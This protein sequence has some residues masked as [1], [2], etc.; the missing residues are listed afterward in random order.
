[1][2]ST[3]T[4]DSAA[5]AKTDRQIIQT[6]GAY[7]GVI[8]QAQLWDTK[9]GATMLG[10]NFMSEHG[11]EA[12]ISFCIVKSDGSESYGMGYLHSIMTCIGIKS[13]NPTKGRVR[14][15]DG[16]IADGIRLR[17]IE[18]PIGL[19]IQ[20]KEDEYDGKRYWR[21]ELRRVFDPMSRKTASEIVNNREPKIIDQLVKTIKDIPM[22][23][24]TYPA[25]RTTAEPAPSEPYP[26]DDLVF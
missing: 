3:I 16:S 12:D 19:V 11:E 25:T 4:C 2:I 14:Q 23:E 17:E 7:A 5:A 9:N 10:L 1:M 24:Q 18:K 21:K 15:R 13:A 20:L 26:D 22:Q 6:S 8:R